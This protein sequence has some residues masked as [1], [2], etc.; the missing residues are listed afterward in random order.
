[1]P[2]L[3]PDALILTS[4]DEATWRLE[5]KEYKA[6]AADPAQQSFLPLLDSFKLKVKRRLEGDVCLN[7]V[8][9]TPSMSKCMM[10]FL[11]VDVALEFD[12]NYS[13]L[14]VIKMQS[15]HP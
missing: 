5:V 13:S 1:M 9:A 4:S 15:K 6:L 10:C 2:T 3:P 14:F 12:L 8:L 11:A 7:A